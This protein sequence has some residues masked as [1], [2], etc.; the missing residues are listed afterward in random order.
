MEQRLKIAKM[1]QTTQR[2]LQIQR[3]EK[4]VL[5]LMKLPNV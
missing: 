2:D 4:N 5:K 1:F 3:R